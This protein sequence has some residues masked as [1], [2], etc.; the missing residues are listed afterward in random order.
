[1]LVYGSTTRANGAG[2]VDFTKAIPNLS[3]VRGREAYM[4]CS[5]RNLGAHKVSKMREGQS[6]VGKVRLGISFLRHSQVSWIHVDKQ[7]LLTVQEHVITANPRIKVQQADGTWTLIINKV[8]LEDRGYYM[9]Q[10]SSQPPK[11]QVGFLDVVGKWRCLH[12]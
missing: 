3:V 8:S 11:T 12:F 6:L 2:D 1:M 9:C 10:I 4:K 5:V 7:S